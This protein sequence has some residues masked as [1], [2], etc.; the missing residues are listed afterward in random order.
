MASYREASRSAKD[1]LSRCAAPWWP[2]ACPV[3]LAYP[4]ALIARA[5]SPVAS[6]CL[7]AHRCFARAR[8]AVVVPLAL[9]L[10]ASR[11][12]ASNATVA[13]NQTERAK[14]HILNLLLSGICKGGGG[15]LIPCRISEAFQI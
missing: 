1:G 4:L 11:P 2:V 8:I 7:L 12:V 9:G 14:A 3:P 6:L 13:T 15:G 5:A 10:L